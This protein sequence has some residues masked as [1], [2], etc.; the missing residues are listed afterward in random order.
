MKVSHQLQQI[1]KNFSIPIKRPVMDYAMLRHLLCVAV[2]A[3]PVVVHAELERVSVSSDGVQAYAGGYLPALSHDGRHVAFLS[4]AE[5]LVAGDSNSERDVFW[6]DRVTGETRRVS[7]ASDGTQAN[8]FSCGISAPAISGDGRYIVFDSAAD[9]LVPDDS[10]DMWDVFMHDSKTGTTQRISVAGDG[11]EPNA[12]SQLPEISKDG[13][14]VSFISSADNL[15]SGDTNGANDIFVRDLETN[16]VE[17]VNVASD[18]TQANAGTRTYWAHYKYTSIS[19]NGRYVA[20]TSLADNLVPGDENGL[21]DVFVHDRETGMTQRVSV[22][23]AGVEGNADSI[24]E[25]MSADGRFILFH[26]T[27]SNLTPN[28]EYGLFLHDRETGETKLVNEQGYY[29]TISENGR[30]LAYSTLEGV[31]VLDRQ[32]GRTSQVS[33]TYDGDE[34]NGNSWDTSISG[35]GKYVGFDSRADNLVLDDSNNAADVFVVENPH[36]F[37]LNLGLNDAWHNP[38]TPGQSFWIT[39]YPESGNAALAWLTYDTELPT[40]GATAELGDPSHR[41][42]TARGKYYDNQAFMLIE[43]TSGGM[44]DELSESQRTSALGSSGAIILTFDNCSSAS[45]E[46]YI[47]TIDRFG[48]IPLRRVAGDNIEICEVLNRE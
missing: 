36:S 33:K 12:F 41:W 32:T 38:M 37:T 26:S 15:V 21:E 1:S 13:R 20:F 46:Y 27:F 19:A 11:S 43:V 10:N 23:S 17:R 28:D 34:A 18:G 9:N 16:M 48:R 47:S 24:L 42:L 40:D 5:N 31:F 2:L 7:V 25:G 3:L 44:F 29:A 8:S 45:V 39:V 22:S 4:K 35:D 14:F 30:H 6:H